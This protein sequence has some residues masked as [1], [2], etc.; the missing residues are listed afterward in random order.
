MPIFHPAPLKHFYGNRVQNQSSFAIA[1]V[2]TGNS[3]SKLCK[4]AGHQCES[5]IYAV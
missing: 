4:V 5:A 3:A 2:A 1:S